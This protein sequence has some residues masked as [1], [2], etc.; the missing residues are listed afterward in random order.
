MPTSSSATQSILGAISL[1]AKYA[2]R[3]SS[4]EQSEAGSETIDGIPE[5]DDLEDS[6]SDLEVPPTPSMAARAAAQHIFGGSPRVE[7]LPS[8]PELDY[9]ESEASEAQGPQD[10]LQHSLQQPHGQLE[11]QSPP[12]AAPSHPA[13]EDAA[14]PATPAQQV[15]WAD[16][17]R[18]GSLHAPQT[19]F[20]SHAGIPRGPSFSQH[21]GS[22]SAQLRRSGPLQ[23][24]PTEDPASRL[25]EAV[26][27]PRSSP[28]PG[29]PLQ[30]G[31]VLQG[32]VM[33]ALLLGVRRGLLGCMRQCSGMLQSL[34]PKFA[35]RAGN[36]Q[37]GQGCD[38]TALR[39]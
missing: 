11:P 35:S 39:I 6:D 36:A 1:P 5:D 38:C 17:Q 18:Q 4:E 16:Q 10:L 19:A 37:G 15:Q 12:P 3:P 28:S 23:P 21:L 32:G 30:G 22:R 25:D 33:M 13:G 24:A 7:R 27:A 26:R 34:P 2:Y 31:A 14:G 8:F 29:S 20:H 9:E